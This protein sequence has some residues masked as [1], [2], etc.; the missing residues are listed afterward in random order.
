MT[1]KSPN[2]LIVE[3][4]PALAESYKAYLARDGLSAHV[5]H[6]GADAIG[7]IERHPIAVAIVDVH[8]PDMNGFEILARLRQME[9]PT[10]VVIITSEGSVNLAVEA[11]RNGAFDFIVKPFSRDRLS[12]TVGNALKHRSLSNR[13]AEVEEETG[14]NPPGRFIGR[15]TAMRAVYRILRSAAP[16]N[17]TVF[18]TGKSGV[19]KELCAEAL[20]KL[21][22]RRDGPFV[23]VN[24]AAI[25]KELME[26]EIFGHTKGAFSGAVGDRKGA[27]LQAD[28]GT[29]FLDEVAEMDIA[30]Q[31]KLLRFLQEKTVQRVGEDQ[32]RKADARIV[33]ATNRDPLAEVSAGRF[34]EDLFYR[35]H[36]VPVELPPLRERNGDVIMIANH[37]LATFSREDGKL[38][39][40]FSR[41]AEE[42]LLAYPWPGNV[43]QLQNVVRSIVVLNDGVEVTAEMLPKSIAAAPALSLLTTERTTAS[44]E[45]TPQAA[46]APVESVPDHHLPAR[47]E[48][49]P[50]E[51]VIR[52]AIETAIDACGGSIP[53]AAG[54][55]QV[56]PSTLYRRIESWRSAEEKH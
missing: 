49:R 17:A 42:I 43:R 11:M 6:N 32:L 33:C 41:S 50:L 23:A 40:G 7:Y 10:D 38:F 45:R 9:A 55:L 48:I 4:V 25:P 22:K 15:S 20:H 1:T 52:T 51:D 26:S 21:S 5:V 36:V 54:A 30:L 27:A 24:C 56:S 35:L 37:F 34:R 12:V 47:G 19:G 46:P 29:L 14:D 18:I 16:T 31:S 44:S 3:D 2:I 13:L 53:K 28:G 8:L 39:T